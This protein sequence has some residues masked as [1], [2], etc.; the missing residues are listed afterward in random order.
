MILNLIRDTFIDKIIIG[1]LYIDGVYQC[2]P[3]DK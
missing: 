2:K 3:E 1:K